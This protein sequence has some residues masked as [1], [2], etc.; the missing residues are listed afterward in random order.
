MRMSTIWKKPAWWIF[1]VL[2]AS[3]LW[4][5]KALALGYYWLT[6]RG[7]EAEWAQK[8]LWLPD[9]QVSIEARVINGL[10]E[11]TSGLTYNEDTNTLYTVINRPRQVAE[12][13]REGELLRL[14]PIVGSS[15]PE[16]ISHIRDH[17]YVIADE[18]ANRL[19]WVEITPGTEE[20]S[21][22]GAPSLSMN[23]DLIHNLGFEGTS[24]DKDLQ[25]LFVVKEKFPMRI[26]MIDGLQQILDGGG[27]N[28][29]I[30]EWKSNRAS[31]LFH[32]DLSSLTFHEP[33]DHMLV[34]S[35]ESRLI[36]EYTEQGVPVS[37]MLL[38][39]GQH[40]LTRSVPQAEGIAYGPEGEIFVV[41]EPN[42]FYRFDR[43]NPAHWLLP[44][45]A[46]TP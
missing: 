33:T 30:Q 3:L 34:L 36:A 21:V 23:F 39:R 24:W 10:S 25:R 1:V 15:D 31:S 32:S 44:S 43:Q 18:E 2:F 40:G 4:Y 6:L 26:Y 13:S 42:L 20:V 17:L 46:V 35:H 14:I 7:G 19:F 8:G 22:I 38:W 41:S 29:S 16:G 12:L 45:L 11:N 28:L 9:Y 27:M 5:Y 37:M